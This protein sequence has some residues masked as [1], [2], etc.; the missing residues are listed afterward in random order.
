M[1]REAKITQFDW[2]KGNINKNWEG[3]QVKDQECEEVFFDLKKK[4][5][6]DVIH[7]T[8][9]KRYILLGQTKLKRLLLIVFTIRKNKIRIISARDLN[10]KEK[11]LYEKKS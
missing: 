4:I 5:L 3:H 2:D 11:Y 10:K 9:E 1:K 7:S 6:K 8:Q